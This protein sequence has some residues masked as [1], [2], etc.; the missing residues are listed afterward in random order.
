MKSGDYSGFKAALKEF[1]ELT[2]KSKQENARIIN[3]E[4]QTIY[5]VKKLSDQRD[6]L[7]EGI[8]QK[9][10]QLLL[11]LLALLGAGMA[12]AVITRQYFRIRQ[13]MKTMYLSL[14]NI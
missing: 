13:A 3:S 5:E 9:N 10:R 6:Q 4:F 14:N 7:Y 12:I 1:N 8:E 2:D 11:S